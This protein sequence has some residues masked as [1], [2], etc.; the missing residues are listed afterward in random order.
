MGSVT[1]GSYGSWKAAW[2]SLTKDSRSE[3][4]SHRS[5]SNGS[6]KLQ[7]SLVASIPGGCDTDISWVFNGT[8]HQQ[9]FLSGSLQIYDVDVITAFCRCTVPFGSQ[10][11]CH[12]SGFLLQGV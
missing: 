1:T 4:A 9:K 3:G 6:S 7:S 10:G 2:I 11:W 12:L 5:G 8:S